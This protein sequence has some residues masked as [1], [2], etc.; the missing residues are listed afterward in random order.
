M[1][2]FIFLVAIVSLSLSLSSC[3]SI[4]MNGQPSIIQAQSVPA[5]AKVSVRGITNGESFTETTPAA[6][7]LSRASDYELTFELGEYES[8]VI[9]IR[10]TIN[11]WF[12]GNLIIGGIPGWIIDYATNDMWVH[13][14]TIASID[15]TKQSYNRDGSVTVFAEVMIND[16]NGFVKT[17]RLPIKL[18]RL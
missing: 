16:E 3:A 15:F 9:I 6:I 13:S 5:G 14:L 1:R 17:Q 4:L 10:R 18:H 2:R 11:G 12:W 8:E 7:T